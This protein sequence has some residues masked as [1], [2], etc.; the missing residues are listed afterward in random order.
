MWFP[1]G[2][3]TRHRAIYIL[4]SPGIPLSQ[5]MFNLDL[6]VVVK[7]EVILNHRKRW[8]MMD[9]TSPFSFHFST[10]QTK[11]SFST[12]FS[13]ASLRRWIQITFLPSFLQYRTPDS[14]I[15]TQ[16]T[17][18]TGLQPYFHFKSCS[19]SLVFPSWIIVSTLHD[20][21]HWLT[22]PRVDQ[23]LVRP[24][25]AVPSGAEWRGALAWTLLN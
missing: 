13:K 2:G 1:L 9:N 21:P 25:R 18:I 15:P 8:M 20:P 24:Q 7:A 6:F 10:L 11:Y 23:C 16:Q 14:T 5:Q 19:P 17:L 22:M 12:N 4:F 3:Q